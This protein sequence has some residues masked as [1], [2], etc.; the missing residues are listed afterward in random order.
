MFKEYP[1]MMS[2]QQ[3]AEAL[4]IGKTSAYRLIKEK[5]I[6]SKHIG[7]KILVPKVCVVDY[8]ISARYSVSNS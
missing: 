4:H 2:V 3:V 5:Q 8:V 7:R 6:G 1:D